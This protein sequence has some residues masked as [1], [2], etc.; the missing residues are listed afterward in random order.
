MDKLTILSISHIHDIIGEIDKITNNPDGFLKEENNLT[1]M[2]D[3]VQMTIG[4]I[5]NIPSSNILYGHTNLIDMMLTLTQENNYNLVNEF[6]NCGYSYKS[7]VY[8]TNEAFSITSDINDKIYRRIQGTN[9]LTNDYDSNTIYQHDDNQLIENFIFEN[10]NE[11]ESSKSNSL[12]IKCLHIWN[13]SDSIIQEPTINIE[14]DASNVPNY[15]IENFNE[16]FK[17]LVKSI[18]PPLNIT[19]TNSNSKIDEIKTTGIGFES[20][21]YVITYECTKSTTSE[22]TNETTGETTSETTIEKKNLRL[23]C[24]L[25]KIHKINFA[26]SST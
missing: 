23:L 12:E 3:E 18:N 15:K 10:L 4:N 2:V 14:Y 24:R 9:E 20:G 5:N 25:I 26:K 19:T 8:K 11:D 17:T 13:A 22:T 1:D 7:I 6:R 21:Y 16:N